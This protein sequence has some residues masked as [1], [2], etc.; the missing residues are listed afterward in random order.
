MAKKTSSLDSS[1]QKYR[2]PLIF[3]LLGLIFLG[4]G[5]LAVQKM[6]LGEAKVEISQTKEEPGLENKLVV[7][8]AGAIIKPGVY[9]LPFQSRVNDLLIMA[10]GLSAEADRDWVARNINLAQKLADGVKIYIPEKGE[11]DF[12]AES[13]QVSGVS[14][15]AGEKININTASEKELDSLWGVGPATAQKMIAGRPYQ[16]IEDLVNKKIIKSNVWTAIKES[17]TVY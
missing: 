3:S 15:K 13:S 10:G 6:L 9:E 4:I 16:K 7:D 11:T 5:I 17:I 2:F 1:L 8:I 14:A 12:S